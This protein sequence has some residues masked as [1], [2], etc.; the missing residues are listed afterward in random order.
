MVS[1]V[2]AGSARLD[3]AGG[4]RGAGGGGPSSQQLSRERTFI[5]SG[6]AVC[7]SS[8]VTP[9]QLLATEVCRPNSQQPGGG[10]EPKPGGKIHPF[11]GQIASPAL[12]PPP[13]PG[14]RARSAWRSESSRRP[15]PAEAGRG[16][17]RRARRHRCPHRGGARKGR[18]RPF[19][20]LPE[21][22]HHGRGARGG[23]GRAAAGRG[24]AGTRP[25]APAR[26]GARRLRLPG[27]AEPA[28]RGRR[29]RLEARCRCRYSRSGSC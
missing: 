5:I 4:G 22:A 20:L 26:R 3:L 18:R 17:A 1:E 24:G 29:R 28:R 14:P 21:A 27:G 12:S 25:G 11:P 9:S 10:G 15:F 6:A 19:S 13:N 23:G 8:T 2:P 7:L 16:V